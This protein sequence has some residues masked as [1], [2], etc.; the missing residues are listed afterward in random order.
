MVPLKVRTEIE[1][2]LK[3]GQYKIVLSMTNA[4]AEGKCWKKE[5]EGMD[6]KSKGLNNEEDE[7][8]EMS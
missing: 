4:I 7:E 6:K 1:N 5:G 8:D 2:E 3:N